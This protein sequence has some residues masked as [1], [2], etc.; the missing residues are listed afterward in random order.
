MVAKYVYEGLAG[1]LNKSHLIR[2]QITTKHQPAV[3]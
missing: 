3:L 2:E 1:K